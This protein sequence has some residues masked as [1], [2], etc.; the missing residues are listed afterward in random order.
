MP[1]NPSPQWGKTV[2]FLFL[3]QNLKIGPCYYIETL[4]E[5]LDTDVCF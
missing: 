4:I 5:L 1:T 2:C 3:E